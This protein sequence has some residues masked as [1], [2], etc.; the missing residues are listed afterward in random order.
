MNIPPAPPRAAKGLAAG[1][2]PVV[3]VVELVV[4]DAGGFVPVDGAVAPW[5]PS[6][7]EKILFIFPRLPGAGVPVEEFVEGV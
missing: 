1:A 7:C 5:L 3:L 6:N 4:L 2:G